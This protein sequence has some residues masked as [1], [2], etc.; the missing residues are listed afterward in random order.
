[1]TALHLP[2]T[3]LTPTHKAG[4]LSA[5]DIVES[6]ALMR[7]VAHPLRIQLLEFIDAHPDVN[8]NVIYNTLKLE[9][10]IT[11]QHLRVLR[12]AD[13]VLTTREGK[14]IRYS[15]NYPKMEALQRAM[16]HL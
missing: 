9:Q 3:H 8:V 2:L 5:A 15:I 11:S 6:A 14:Y 7:A 10:S 1:M 4:P 16:T 12:E 13:L